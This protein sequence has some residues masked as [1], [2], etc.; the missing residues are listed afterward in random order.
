MKDIERKRD[1]VREL[2]NDIAPS[3]DRLNHI[4]SLDV[5]KVWRRR[6]VRIVRRRGARRILDMATG[7]GDLA[8][9]LANGIANSTIFG[10]DLSPEMLAVAE[11]K[12]VSRGLDERITL[13]ECDVEHIPLENESVDAATVAF[14]VRNFEHREAAIR[15]IFRTIR[16]GGHFVVLE[17]SRPRNPLVRAIYNLYS[18]KLLPII[19]GIISKNRP[20][21]SYLPRSIDEFPS[22]EKFRQMLLDAGFEF[23]RSRSQSWGIAQIYIARKAK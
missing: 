1:E 3:Y 14:G 10:A 8:I 17:F 6:V 7:T 5:D 23:V 15:E 4:L 19:G 20:A 2:F 11:R 18:H 12:I 9:A 13:E 16:P 22:P 21:Y